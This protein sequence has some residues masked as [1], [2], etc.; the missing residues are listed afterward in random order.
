MCAALRAELRRA[1]PPSPYALLK[2]FGLAPSYAQSHS[3][4][5]YA[6]LREARALGGSPHDAIVD[7]LD[8]ALRAELGRS[9]PRAPNAVV[10]EHSLSSWYLQR[11][12]SEACA[13]LRKVRAASGRNASPR[14]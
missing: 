3:P 7:R 4:E 1:I 14:R 2:T 5:A 10:K 12:C 6:R 11:Y 13:L 9:K 8:A